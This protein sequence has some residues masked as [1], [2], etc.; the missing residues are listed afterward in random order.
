VQQKGSLVNADR[1]RFDFAHNA[2][3]TDDQVRQ[4][5]AFTPPGR[6]LLAR[7]ALGVPCFRPA[8]GPFEAAQPPETK[9]ESVAFRPTGHP[10]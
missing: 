10:C 3:V 9:E 2:P 5:E 1:T 8:M 6:Q 4:V 7:G